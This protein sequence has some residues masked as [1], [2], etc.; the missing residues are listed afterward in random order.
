MRKLARI[1]LI[2]VTGLLISVS[3]EAAPHPEPRVIVNVLTVQGPHAR[4]DVERAARHGWGRIVRCYKKNAARAK[5]KVNFAL[6]VSRHGKVKTA[7]S[8]H[9]TFQ[10]SALSQCLAEALKGLPMPTAKADS[11]ANA[12]I[13]LAPGDPK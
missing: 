9:S 4:A 10:N 3:G 12:E 6:S 11:L 1:L 8:T 13:H 7:Q 5:G 2:P